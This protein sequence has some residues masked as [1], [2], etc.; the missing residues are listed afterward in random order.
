MFKDMSWKKGLLLGVGLLFTA[1]C[2]V[3]SFAA[4]IAPK[5]DSG[6]AAIVATAVPTQKPTEEPT[7]VPTEVPCS[8]Q[9]GQWANSMVTAIQ[10]QNVGFQEGSDGNFV[11]AQSTM[12]HVKEF[13]ETIELP[14][15][16][17]D[18]AKIDTL[19]RDFFDNYELSTQYAIDGDYK[20]SVAYAEKAL[21]DQRL[22]NALLEQVTARYK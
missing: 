8:E 16:D 14:T 13:Y 1:C 9:L 4:A 11:D 18:I 2:A 22:I 15:C 20:K 3:G 17:S 5:K 10:M 19:Y 7:V 21:E 6:A 12:R